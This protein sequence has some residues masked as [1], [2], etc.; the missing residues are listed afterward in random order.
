M[1]YLHI[2]IVLLIIANFIAYKIQKEAAFFTLFLLIY[3]IYRLLR[4][5]KDDST[6]F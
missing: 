3:Y 6:R 1:N 4:Y 5:G 2:R